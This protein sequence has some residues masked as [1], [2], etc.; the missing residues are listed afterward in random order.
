MEGDDPILEHEYRLIEP[1]E[2]TV[3]ED[4]AIDKMLTTTPCPYFE[5]GKG[6][7]LKE[8]EKQAS[9][10]CDYTSIHGIK[11]GPEWTVYHARDAMSCKLR[12]RNQCLEASVA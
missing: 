6:C 11:G 12:K 7:L 2:T 5:P 4:P 10:V 9:T 8:S 1:D 3:F